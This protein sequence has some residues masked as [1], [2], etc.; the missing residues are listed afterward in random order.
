MILMMKP[1]YLLKCV[2][3]SLSLILKL[4]IAKRGMKK[5]IVK[6]RKRQMKRKGLVIQ[7][8]KWLKIRIRSGRKKVLM[9]TILLTL[10]T[11]Q[12][13]VTKG[14]MEVLLWERNTKI[15]TKPNIMC[16]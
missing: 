11:Y 2:F 12:M 6:P 5:K 1:S 13:I 3:I 14:N 4:L 16:K 7:R 10:I 9:L 8:V 15:I